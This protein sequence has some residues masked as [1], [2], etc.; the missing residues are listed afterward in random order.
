MDYRAAKSP[1]ASFLPRMWCYLRFVMMLATCCNS[2]SKALVEGGPSV[3]GELRES[4]SGWLFDAARVVS[5]TDDYIK[6]R[7][8]EHCFLLANVVNVVSY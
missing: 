7:S 5:D 3:Q 8:P 4:F 6:G 2:E 1:M